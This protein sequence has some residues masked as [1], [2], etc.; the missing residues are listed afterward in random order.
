MLDVI[1]DTLIDTVKI[2]P[3]LFVAFL[4]IEVVEHKF[5]EKSKRIMTGSKKYGPILGGVLGAL[6]QCGFSVM[7]TNLYITRIITMGTLIAVYLSTSDEML[8][9]LVSEHADIGVILKIILIKVIIGIIAGIIID[10]IIIHKK[11]EEKYEEFD[12]C[13][14]DDCHCEK[15]IFHSTLVHTFKTTIFILIT[16]FIINLL[17]F[18]V[19][20]DIL[21]KILMKDTF[22]SPFLASLIGLIPNCGASVILTELYLNGVVTISTLISGLLTGSGIALLVLFKSNK[23]VFENLKILG[24]VYFI[25]SLSGIIL[26]IIFKLVGGF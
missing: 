13:H 26:E 19:G 20:E 24:L 12:L 23:N 5:S 6:P 10:K 3:F 15:G 22:L 1:Y 25:G 7:A 11:E 17:M 8:P 21:S 2:L 9:I 18:Y 14:D 16:T 4:L